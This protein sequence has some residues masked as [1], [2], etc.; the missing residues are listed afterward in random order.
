MTVLTKVCLIYSIMQMIVQLRENKLE[1]I[2]KTV[3]YVSY[4]IWKYICFNV[5]SKFVVV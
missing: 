1:I 2:T 3:V 5:L 4:L